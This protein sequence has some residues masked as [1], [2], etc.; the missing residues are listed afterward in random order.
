MESFE[1]SQE[2]Q[3]TRLDKFLLSRRPDLSRSFLQSVI[4]EGNVQVNG[5]SRKANYSVKAGDTITFEIPA[6]TPATAQAED[7]PLQVL[8]EDDALL[9]VNK[10]AGMVVHPAA[11]H[12]SGTLV[13]AVLGHDPEIVT[14][15]R[16]RAGIVHRLD[17]DTSGVMLVAKNDAAMHN[18]QKQ[19]S[20]RHVHKTYLALVHGIVQTPRGKIDA[21]LGRDP[22]DRKRMAIVHPQTAR[23]GVNAR[24]S[25]TDFTV[26][27]HSEK[28]T[29]LK[30]EPETGR[31]H[32][33]RVHLA[34]LK[35]PVVAD[36]L[37]GKKKNDLG[38]TRQFLHAYRIT[39]AHPVTGK[40]MTLTAPLPPELKTAS[41]LAGI[42]LGEI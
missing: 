40:E 36:E 23:V 12:A 41:A 11:G 35:H 25:V 37:Y 39:F 33:I 26:L 9:V 42:E 27:A 1:V 20:S 16:E 3:G 13:N 29:L 8:Y 7:I 24:D 17:R 14:G 6:P 31:T 38:L 15:N 28:Y 30:V 18:L 2:Q 21:P 32:Q 34:F 4:G 10:P 5:A 22:R 19:F